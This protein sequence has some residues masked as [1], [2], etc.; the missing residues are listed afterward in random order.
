MQFVRN[1]RATVMDIVHFGSVQ[2]WQ[3]FPLAAYSVSDT[4]VKA[5]APRFQSEQCKYWRDNGF[6]PAYAWMN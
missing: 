2:N 1:V 3:P 5:D 6:F 4:V